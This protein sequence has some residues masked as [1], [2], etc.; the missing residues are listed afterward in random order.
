M[1]DNSSYSE[2]RPKAASAI[3]ILNIIFGA[4]GIM[5]GLGGIAVMGFTRTIFMSFAGGYWQEYDMIAVTLRSTLNIIIIIYVLS[6]AVAVIGL[7]SGAGLLGRKKWSVITANAYAA[8]TILLSIATYFF[9][10]RI[11]VVILQNPLLIDTIPPDERFALDILKNIIPGFTGAVSIIFGS[12][13]PAVILALINRKNI[14]E[15]YHSSGED[16]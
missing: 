6:S 9:I 5:G 4:L 11:F 10:R 3:G 14:R 13:Y 7:V 15:Y 1:P 16:L 2:A 12:A 8:A